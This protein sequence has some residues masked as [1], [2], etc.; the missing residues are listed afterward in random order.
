MSIVTVGVGS[1]ALD[2]S[3]EAATKLGADL[4]TPGP[5]VVEAVIPQIPAARVLREGTGR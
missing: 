2:V 5:A 4:P 1:Q 3:P